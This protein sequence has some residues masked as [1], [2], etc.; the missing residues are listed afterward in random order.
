MQDS[1]ELIALYL[2][3]QTLRKQP[4][5]PDGARIR[6]RCDD[7]KLVDE[8]AP[9]GTLRLHVPGTAHDV[10]APQLD[11]EPRLDFWY[12]NL[13]EPLRRTP[14]G[15][16]FMDLILDV[17]ISLDL[18]EWKWKDEDELE[19]AQARRIISGEQARVIRAEGERAIQRAL[20][21]QSPFAHG[22]ER[23]SPPAWPVPTM[24]A[25][26]HLLPSRD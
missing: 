18:S 11:T 10:W 25:N 21:R 13:Q 9:R 16:D 7:W 22:W 26:W 5:T 3:P 14:L 23:W 24:P 4:R 1:P 15:F 8:P 2:A 19:E 20:A 17:V 12:V 6:L